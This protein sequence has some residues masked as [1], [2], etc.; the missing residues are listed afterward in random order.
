MS[1]PGEP[2]PEGTREYS[3]EEGVQEVLRRIEEKL[4]EKDVVV[5]AF[6]STGSPNVG[7]TSLSG[8][9]RNDLF[10]RNIFS[11]DAEQVDYEHL[12]MVN[13]NL[14]PNKSTGRYTAIA[15]TLEEQAVTGGKLVILFSTEGAIF[16]REILNSHLVEIAQAFGIREIKE[17]DILIL[18][19]RP[20][21]RASK[22]YI[23][24][25]HICNELAVDKYLKK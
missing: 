20:D 9:L 11:Y 6:N 12:K 10:S 24:D 5:V 17:I 16:N 22:G 18:L 14:D 1:E 13:P 3:F 8:R 21:R 25:V 7:K 19:D 23:G 2:K 15:H 4:K